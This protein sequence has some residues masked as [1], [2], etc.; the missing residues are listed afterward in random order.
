MGKRKRK[1]TT[2]LIGK[3]IYK[4]PEAR[5]CWWCLHNKVSD[6]CV[7]CLYDTTLF[8]ITDGA[9]GEFKRSWEYGTWDDRIDPERD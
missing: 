3:A 1:I 2:G 8:E 4:G 6:R 5:E 9:Q 7:R